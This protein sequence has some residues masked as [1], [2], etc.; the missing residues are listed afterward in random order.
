MTDYLV[1]LEA[2][3]RI[4]AEV[5]RHMFVFYSRIVGLVILIFL[6]L[7]FTST[8]VDFLNTRILETGGGTIFTFLYLVWFLILF[9]VFFFQWTDYYLD[10]WVLTNE[11]IFDIE[12]RGMF[13]RHIS[14]FR[15]ERVQDVTVEVNGLLAT[16]LK[17]GDVH[18]HTAGE[19]T[20]FIIKDAAD[21]LYIK[22][23]IMEE[24]GK[25]MQTRAGH[26]TNQPTPASTPNI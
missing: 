12:Q 13:S 16:F 5:R 1:D 9:V 14:V 8:V 11:R 24:H 2:N 6:P 10:V 19:A 20:D 23:I 25:A 26:N 18:I 3:E 22:K 17:F 21:P 4:V 15:L 7:A